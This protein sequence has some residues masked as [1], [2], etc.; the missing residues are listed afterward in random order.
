[1][2]LALVLTFKL[3]LVASVALLFTSK[4]VVHAEPPVPKIGTTGNPPIKQEKYLGS[5]RHL[6]RTFI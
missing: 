5:Q 4:Q 1:L 2:A 6:W 3:A